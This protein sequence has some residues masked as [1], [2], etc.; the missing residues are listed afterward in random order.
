MFSVPL[1]FQVT[2]GTSNAK[3]GSHLVPAVLGNTIGG[4]LTGYVIRRH[5]SLPHPRNIY[6]EIT[7]LSEPVNTSTSS[8]SPSWPP[9]PPMPSFFSAGT[10]TNNF[11]SLYIF[12]GGLG[13]GMASAATFI[14]L[15]AKIATEDVAVATAGLYLA[16][17]IGQV[18]GVSIGCSVQKWM[19][20]MLL[21]ERIRVPNEKEVTVPQ[22]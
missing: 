4:L 17:S 13:L 15:T 20:K 11:E 2:E 9:L 5:V 12:P 1:Y 22:L 6:N 14:A 7:A 8:L 18:L 19:L 16:G 3:A 21:V 10:V